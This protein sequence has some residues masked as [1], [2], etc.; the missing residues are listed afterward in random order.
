MKQNKI[1]QLNNKLI[2]RLMSDLDDPDKCTPGLYQ[3]VRGIITDNQ[4]FVDRIDGEAL[5]KATESVDL[6]F[7]FKV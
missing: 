6:P 1:T 4:E 7:K 2:D 5:D 3:V